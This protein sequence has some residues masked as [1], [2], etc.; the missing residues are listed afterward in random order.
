MWRYLLSE[1]SDAVRRAKKNIFL[2]S[3]KYVLRQMQEVLDVRIAELLRRWCFPRNA[4]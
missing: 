1:E 4:L 3:E 2:V